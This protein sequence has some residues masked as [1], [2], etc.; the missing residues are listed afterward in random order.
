MIYVYVLRSEKDGFLYT[1]CTESWPRVL[2]SMI[3]EGVLRRRSEG[4]FTSSIT[5]QPLVNG[6]HFAGRNIS[7]AHM[8]S[9]TSNAV[10]RLLHRLR[11]RTEF[12]Q[13]LR[14]FSRTSLWLV[15]GSGFS[16]LPRLDE[17]YFPR[18]DAE[19]ILGELA[20][21]ASK[22]AALNRSPNVSVSKVKLR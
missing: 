21:T 16:D 15:D 11:V 20:I 10:S 2:I 1:G 3:A 9:V 13:R 18:V 4:R 8:E 7:K 12:R 6:M 22:I 14:A 19:S 17:K 5:K